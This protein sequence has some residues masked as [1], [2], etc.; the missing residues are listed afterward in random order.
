M[1]ISWKAYG[2]PLLGPPQGFWF[3]KTGLSLENL[4]FQQCLGVAYAAGL[5]F[6]QA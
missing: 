6:A 3:S 2:I 4:C 5:D 1:R